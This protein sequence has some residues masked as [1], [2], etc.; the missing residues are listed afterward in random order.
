MHVDAHDVAPPSL[1]D[2]GRLQPGPALAGIASALG[3]HGLIAL[4]VLG[5]AEVSKDDDAPTSYIEEHVIAAKFVQLGKPPEPDALPQRKVPR[6]TTAPKDSI[7]VSKDMDP[8]KPEKDKEETPK[9]A[10][11]DLLTRLGDRAKAFAEIAEAQEREGDPEGL[12]EGTETEA[13][14]GD[15]Y[16]GKLVSFFKR[17]WTI[18]NTLTDTDGLLTIATVELTRDLHVGPHRIVKSSGVPLFDQ[19]VEDRFEQLR[20]LGTTLP[21]PPPE[22]APQFV[23]K[24]MTI[25]FV[26]K[27]Q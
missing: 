14:E 3:V 2:A 20:T 19:S 22:V 8:P 25:I 9:E 17:G 1:L 24:K 16:L 27:K 4:M 26:G 7:A 10:E 23:G 21:E 12:V 15:L 18:P 6:K 13:A 5:V 11:E